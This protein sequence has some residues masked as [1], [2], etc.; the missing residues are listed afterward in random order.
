[1]D[2]AR[3]LHRPRRPRQL[4][5]PPAKPSPDA[6]AAA[7]LAHQNRVIHSARLEPDQRSRSARSPGVNAVASKPRRTLDDRFDVDAD[8]G[9]RVERGER[10]GDSVGMRDRDGRQRSIVGLVRRGSAGAGRARRRRS[11]GRPDKSRAGRR[12]ARAAARPPWPRSGPRADAIA[13]ASDP[14]RPGSAARSCGP[15]LSVLQH[16]A[17]DR[18]A[19]VGRGLEPDRLGLGR[20]DVMPGPPAAALR[21]PR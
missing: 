7:S 16:V 14:P 3:C 13:A 6:L 10:D 15:E 21:R 5:G 8:P 18:P 1:M 19:H 2:D 17:P 20:S 9:G 11:P 12:R 4:A